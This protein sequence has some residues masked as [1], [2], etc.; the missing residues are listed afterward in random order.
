[1]FI[2]KAL[3]LIQLAEVRGLQQRKQVPYAELFPGHDGMEG[4]EAGVSETVKGEGKDFQTSLSQCPV[5]CPA[6]RGP[7]AARRYSLQAPLQ[8]TFKALH[9]FTCLEV[10]VWWNIHEN[11]LQFLA[12]SK[13]VMNWEIKF[14]F[15]FWH[16]RSLYYKNIL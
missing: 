8:E 9:H 3:D 12:L 14:S 11:I 2:D 5:S 1:M 15:I 4:S 13:G 7:R 10:S 6:W 16:T